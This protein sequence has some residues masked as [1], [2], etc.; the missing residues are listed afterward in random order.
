MNGVVVLAKRYVHFRQYCAEHCLNYIETIQISDEVDG[1]KVKVMKN[2]VLVEL[3]PTS[4][5]HY[6]KFNR[7]ISTRVRM[8]ECTVVHHMLK[9]YHKI[10]K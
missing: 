4:L 10:L 7:F 8:K 1:R 9:T 2:F 5:T 3:W 6:P